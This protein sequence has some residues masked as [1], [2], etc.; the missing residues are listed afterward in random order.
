MICNSFKSFNK[1]IH[2]CSFKYSEIDKLYLTGSQVEFF[3]KETLSKDSD[4][5]LIVFFSTNTMS[6]GIIPFF[7]KVTTQLNI[8]IHP[9]LIFE[10]EK[11]IKLGI[12][13]YRS[14][15]QNGILLYS[16]NN[17]ELGAGVAGLSQTSWVNNY[18]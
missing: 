13:E 17:Y 9:L 16:K 7:S 1:V 8:I 5:D 2:E 18:K 15:I 3:K 10:N 4:I 14:A 6:P 11:K 12:N